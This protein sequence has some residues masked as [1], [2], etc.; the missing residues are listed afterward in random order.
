M[1]D[2]TNTSQGLTIHIINKI[3]YRLGINEVPDIFFKIVQPD[4]RRT[5]IHPPTSGPQPQ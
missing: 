1:V 2:F 4:E 5:G 3:K